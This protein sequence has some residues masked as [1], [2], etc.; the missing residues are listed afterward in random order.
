M[1]YHTNF[2]GPTSVNWYI[3]RGLVREGTNMPSELWMGGSINWIKGRV[4]YGLSTMDQQSW[5][6]LTEWLNSRTFEYHL[7]FWDLIHLF[8][9]ECDH[10]IRWA[11]DVWCPKCFEL[12]PNHKET[13]IGVDENLNDLDED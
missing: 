2:F 13:C 11:D 8:E 10:K 6:K 9:G 4:G 7:E 3:D 5:N 12:L 1:K